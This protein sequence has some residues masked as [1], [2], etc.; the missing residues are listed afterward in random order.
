MTHVFRL[1]EHKNGIFV[2]FFQ[3]DE[4]NEQHEQ[5]EPNELNK[6]NELH[7]RDKQDKKNG[8]E[9]S[10]HKKRGWPKWSPS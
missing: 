2:R 5:D 7:E 4:L 10:V 6:P 1:F 8:R 9:C 3:Q